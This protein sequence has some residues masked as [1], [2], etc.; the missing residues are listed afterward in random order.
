MR[1][2]ILSVLLLAA[3]LAYP[4]P[5]LFTWKQNTTGVVGYNNIPADVSQVFYSTN[6]VYVKS[7][8][9]PSYNI[10]PWAMNP[11]VPTNQ[12]WTFKI[13]RFPVPNTGTLTSVGNG[14]IGVFKNGVV[15]FNA[16][17]AMTYNNGGI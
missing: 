11:N 1:K 4:Q 2:I 17:D 8:G 3:S 16:G 10:G 6:F 9:I 5:E 15:A 7:S 13:A 14:Q 12:N